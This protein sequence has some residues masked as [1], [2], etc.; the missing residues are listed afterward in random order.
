MSA[1]RGGGFLG[2]AV[3]M[4]AL[5]SC[6]PTRPPAFAPA[7]GQSRQYYQAGEFQ[8]AIDVN[9]AVLDK[10]PAEAAVR[11]AYIKTLEGIHGQAQAAV[12]AKDYAAAERLFT[13]LLNNFPKYGSLGKSLSFSAPGLNRSIRLCRTTFDERR[14]AQHLQA[15]EYDR[16]LDELRAISAAEL[17]DPGRAAAL[18][19]TMAE[20]KRRA[21]DAA[22]SR[23]FVEAGRAY[24][25]LVAHYAD[26]S[27][28]GLKLPFSRDSV[29]EGLKR[30]QSELTRQG[31]EHYRKGELADAIAV[32]QGLLRFD[33]ANAEIRKA[34]ETA[35]QQQKA[36]KKNRP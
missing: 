10:F 25:V 27:K 28:L 32:W 13:L 4:M 24:A 23:N 15:G 34:V 8:Q 18:S 36:I 16:A 20:I 14:T 2:W 11:E 31:L 33:P 12:A 7:L 26:A 6:S 19:N 1:N 9:A 30:C 3:L 35:R 21:D 5:A 29:D 17:R 22:S